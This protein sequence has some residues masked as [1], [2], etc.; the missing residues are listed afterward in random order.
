[1]VRYIATLVVK[2]ADRRAE[3]HTE[4]GSMCVYNIKRM[5]SCIPFSPSFLTPSFALLTRACISHLEMHLSFLVASV[6]VVTIVRS[7]SGFHTFGP[8][9]TGLHSG[10]EDLGS[11]SLY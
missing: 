5:C 8:A 4:C 1:V 10:F 7:L 6:T 2:T 9:P 11:R 3:P